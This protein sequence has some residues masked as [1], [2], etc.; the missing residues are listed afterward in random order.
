MAVSPDY[1]ISG[2]NESLLGQKSVFDPHAPY[3]EIV[4]EVELFCKFAQHSRLDGRGDILVRDEMVGNQADALP[5]EY[6]FGPRASEGFDRERGRYIVSKREI[7]P[8]FHEFFRENLGLP[9]V[10]RQNLFTDS[11]GH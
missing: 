10:I 3:F 9:G 8:Y 1:D 6:L 4:R 11:L 5:V 7:D 2:Q